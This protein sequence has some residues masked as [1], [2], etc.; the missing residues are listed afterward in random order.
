VVYVFW[1]KRIDKGRMAVEI[2]NQNDL[3]PATKRQKD[4][5]VSR[6]RVKEIR[7]VIARP[8]LDRLW[9]GFIGNIRD[10]SGISI[11]PLP[12]GEG[13]S[14]EGVRAYY[15]VF[16]SCLDDLVN[17]SFAYLLT[18]EAGFAEL[19]LD[20]M[21]TV[22]SWH[23]WVHP[24]HYPKT[25][26]LVS[27]EISRSLALASQ[28]LGKSLPDSERRAVSKALYDR[29]F[30]Q[31]ISG[32]LNETGWW[33]R[34][35]S[36]NW[37]AVVNGGIGSALVH[38]V[39]ENALLANVLNEII[40]RLSIYLK[41]FEPDGG[42]LEGI[43]YWSYG[44]TWYLYFSEAVKNATR[45]KINPALVTQ[46][47]KAKAFPLHCYMPPDRM[48]NFSDSF[49][50]LRIGL[51]MPL[52]R[53]AHEF[54][55]PALSWLA[56]KII[57]LSGGASSPYLFIWYPGVGGSAP[58]RK[59]P[60]GKVFRKI[61]WAVLR[62]SWD[63]D[64][65][66]VACKAGYADPYEHTHLDAGTFILSA[67]EKPLITDL[68][69]GKYSADY[70]SPKRWLCTHANTAGHNTYIIGGRHQL[71][72]E[73]HS[74]RITHF[75]TVDRS[76][77]V[78]MDITG[79]YPQEVVNSLVRHFILLDGFE[80]VIFDE[81]D[82]PENTAVE[83]RLHYRGRGKAL[84]TE[85]FLVYN[86]PARLQMRF[87]CSAP[88]QIGKFRHKTLD[89]NIERK[90]AFNEKPGRTYLSLLTKSSAGKVFVM[91]VLHPF[92]SLSSSAAPR[93]RIQM[94]PTKENLSVL[95]V[96]N[97]FSRRLVWV[98]RG[99]KNVLDSVC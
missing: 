18:G 11:D 45:G 71:P 88:F 60:A 84:S 81:I 55:D 6:A 52:L 57:S 4:L 49:S 90:D 32:M 14:H 19:A 92:M 95:V 75:K 51:S 43:S 12:V 15:G 91:S 36:T 8:P 2:I 42:W 65:V 89:D 25:I 97:K 38:F 27:A 30:E 31:Y 22:L 78:R 77:Y 85:E 58:P 66:V 5:F 96:V 83:A 17:S 10:R 3:L 93:V 26:D 46:M 82:C 40:R 47:K 67:F 94:R 37:C 50:R 24:A 61:Q 39:E 20:R 53:L 68:G 99:G 21:R 9:E 33:A 73:K 98:E 76:E 74:G 1:S 48:V 41:G 80:C 54:K 16:R 23:T 64:A 56:S 29:I 86:A 59:T 7:G 72:L 13:R 44:I 34:E 70:F 79:C 62:S 28:W 69:R 87:A 35:C 63:G